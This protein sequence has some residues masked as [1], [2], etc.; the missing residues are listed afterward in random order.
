[1]HR[2]AKWIFLFL[3]LLMTAGARAQDAA[4]TLAA[5][6][7]AFAAGEWAKAVED[8]QAVT[9]A[10]AKNARAWFQMGVAQKQ[11]GQFEPAV[12][13]FEQSKQAGGFGPPGFLTF[14]QARSYT[15][16]G[17]K[18]KAFELL[19][20][21]VAAG[22]SNFQGLDTNPDLASLRGDAR[23]GEVRAQAQRNAQPCA[24][25]PEYR[26]FDFWLGEWNVSPTGNP[27][28]AAGV[29]VIELILNQCIVYENWTGANGYTGK[30]FNLYNA[31]TKKWEQIWVDA[32]GGIVKFEGEFKDGILHYYADTLGRDGSAVR[33]HLQFIPQGP[34]QVRQFSQQSTDGGKTWSVEYDLTYVRKKPAS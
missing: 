7:Q 30:S 17:N 32:I 11:L 13:S 10:D 28:Q 23:F 14:W 15:A 24:H 3:F 21:M 1:M 25:N 6:D 8:Y 19:R 2:G 18:E 20:A 4:A 5:A 27:S 12:A 22:F 34:D 33:R 29:N 31:A 9:K 16:M 26:K